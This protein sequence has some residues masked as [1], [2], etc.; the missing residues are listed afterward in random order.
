MIVWSRVVLKFQLRFQ[1]TR[2]LGVRALDA[3]DPLIDE[4]L[5][6]LLQEAARLGPTILIRRALTVG[7]QYA[8]PPISR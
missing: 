5:L 4:Y 7:F 3:S 6:E 1:T 8:R 2:L